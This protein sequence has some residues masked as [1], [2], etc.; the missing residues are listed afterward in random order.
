MCHLQDGEDEELSAGGTADVCPLSPHQPL[1]LSRWQVDPSAV[2]S[3]CRS[4]TTRA[5]LC[6]GY[7]QEVTRCCL[8]IARLGRYL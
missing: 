8:T 4:A 1:A 7:R 2:S 5:E 3:D 6:L